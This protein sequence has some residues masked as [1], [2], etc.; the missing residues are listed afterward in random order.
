MTAQFGGEPAH[1]E[2]ISDIMA[3]A[4]N[5]AEDIMFFAQ[6]F[7]HKNLKKNREIC[8]ALLFT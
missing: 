2:R 1:L 7:F 8:T 4:L 5:M 3:Y 6:K